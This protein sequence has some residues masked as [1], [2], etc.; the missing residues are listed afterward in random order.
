MNLVFLSGAVIT[1]LCLF[2]LHVSILSTLANLL[3]F[4]FFF[5]L[6]NYSCFHSEFHSTFET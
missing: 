4:L 2:T 6:F 3:F 1:N 5:L